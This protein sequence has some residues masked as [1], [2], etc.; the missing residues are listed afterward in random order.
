M[1]SRPFFIN[2]VYW[3]H[4]E[5][6]STEEAPG[7]E[8]KK[9]LFGFLPIIILI[10]LLFSIFNNFITAT[11]AFVGT[12]LPFDTPTQEVYIPG[13]GIGTSGTG[14]TETYTFDAPT[15]DLL[16]GELGAISDRYAQ[17][18]GFEMIQL[19][20]SILLIIAAIFL[21][22][23]FFKKSR[24]FPKLFIWFLIV[25]AAAAVAG[26]FKT[27]FILVGPSALASSAF[28][29]PTALVALIVAAWV[30][31]MKRSERIRL[32]FVN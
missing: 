11:V 23:F 25:Q 3:Y 26:T 1:E 22:Y 28:W 9:G 12:Q 31:S 2:R 24:R 5:N 7:K 32:T 10:L 14:E 21:L 18:G 8:G 19:V 6:M 16:S 27:L 20:V 13:T 15:N 4:M 30:V 29:L 17:T